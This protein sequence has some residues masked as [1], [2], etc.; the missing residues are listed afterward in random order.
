MQ[1]FE[2]KYK[3]N[4]IDYLWYMGR[5]AWRVPLRAWPTP[6]DAVV[7][8]LVGTPSVFLILFVSSDAM[9][10]LLCT[11]CVIAASFG[12]EWLLKISVHTGTRAG[13]FPPLSPTEALQPESAFLDFGCFVADPFRFW[14]CCS[15]KY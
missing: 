3:F 15:I 8:S 1:M 7:W 6:L 13:T 2:R 9:E 10:A 14:D 11:A 4:V 12:Y 5:D